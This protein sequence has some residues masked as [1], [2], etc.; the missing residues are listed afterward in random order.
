MTTEVNLLSPEVLA[1]PY[2]L[3]HQLRSLDPVHWNPRPAFW[4][5]TRY[6]DVQTAL[7]DQ[8]LS[9]ARI[10]AFMNELPAPLRQVMEPLGHFSSCQMLFSH[11]PDHTRLRGLVNKAFTPRMVEQQ[12]PTIERTVDQ[13]LDAVQDAGRMDVIR[14]LAYPLPV[15]VIAEMLGMPH[16]D[17]D[18]FKRWSDDLVAVIGTFSTAPDIVQRAQRARETLRELTEYFHELFEQRRRQPGDDL[19]SALLAAEE[20]GDMLNEEEL[21]ANVMLLLAAGHETTTNLIGNGLL[22]LL[23]HPDQLQKLRDDPALVERAVEELLR[24][25]SSIQ[26]T[27]RLAT[28]D[29]ELGGKQ[30]RAGQFVV[31]LLGAANRDPAQFSD[32]DR[33]DVTRDEDRHLAFGLGIHFCLGAPLARLEAQIAFAGLL[34]RFPRL[35]LAGGAEWQAEW[36]ENFFFRGLTSLPV[37][38]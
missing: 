22:A 12:R 37:T 35:Q 14:D 7:R 8:R 33:L 34:Q 1:D 32:P 30:I 17:R 13:L 20:R 26:G 9:A 21:D 31:L 5:V 3:Y 10:P 24:Y 29:L 4:V 38:F 6:A 27:V 15:I 18:R 36:H 23:Q 19:I 2:P 16:A 28:E 25:N 11:P